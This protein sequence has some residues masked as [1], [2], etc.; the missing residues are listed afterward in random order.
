[1]NATMIEK[2]RAL[3]AWPI[4]GGTAPQQQGIVTHSEIAPVA[5]VTQ[6]KDGTDLNAVWTEFSELL[7]ME[8]NEQATLTDV[9]TFTTD[10][11]F[12][13]I[14]QNVAVGSMDVASEM[15]VPKAAGIPGDTLPVGFRLDWF[16]KRTAYTWRFL[17]DADIRQVRSVMDGVIAA[18]RKLRTNLVLDRLFTPTERSNFEGNRVFGLYNGTD[19]ITPPPY[20]GR[21]FASDTTHYVKS[22]AA[23]IDSG[24]VE[25]L[26]A[27]VTRKGFGTQPGSA[28]LAI[29]NPDEGEQ[30]MSWR[31]GQ[32]N[33]T[34]IFAKWD[35]IPAKDQP[36]FLT[37]AGELVGEQV[38]GQ[39]F[40]LK[41]QGSYGVSNVVFS[42]YIPRG[43]FA[44]CASYGPNSPLNPI[45]FREHPG[46]RGLQLIPGTYANYPVI[47][48]FARRGIGVGTRHRGAAAVC[49][50]GTG[51]TYTA[52]TFELPR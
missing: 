9:L 1:M 31:A 51:S 38:P 50:I 35:F 45:G 7:A 39:L 26:I 11:A 29:F 28:V 32:E 5:P 40:G 49:Q 46:A 22:G 37:P 18:D 41:V 42:D 34:G 13:V 14:P 6:L 33:R 47:D 15:G 23:D 21:T 17:L 2:Q 27:L 44:V 25:A 36:P 20:H 16:D 48:S 8:N 43:Y 10:N 3:A 24:D 19:G 4:W 52:P 12:E 30:V